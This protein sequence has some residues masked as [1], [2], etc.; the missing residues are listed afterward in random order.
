MSNKEKY[1]NLVQGI[2]A[3]DSAKN[4]K[5]TNYQIYLQLCTIYFGDNKSTIYRKILME[6][7][8]KYFQPRSEYYEA[9]IFFSKVCS[10]IITEVFFIEM[11]FAIFFAYQLRKFEDIEN[12]TNYFFLKFDLTDYDYIKYYCMYLFYQGQY[13]LSNRV[14]FN[15]LFFFDFLLKVSVIIYNYF[16]FIYQN[17]E[18][19]SMSFCSSLNFMNLYVSIYNVFQIESLK[20]ICLLKYIVDDNFKD[21]INKCLK[22][23]EDFLK[24]IQ[25]ETYFN[26][27][28]FDEKVSKYIFL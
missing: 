2:I 1:L 19:S 16:L 20:R 26:I 25:F 12:I 7:I 27:A 22:I 15:F 4:L 24:T 18:R 17:Y 8:F 9:H 3:L 23:N 14:F 10:E 11:A 21:I 5:Y 28:F 13:Y 6:T